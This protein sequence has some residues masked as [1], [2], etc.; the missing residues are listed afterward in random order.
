[1]EETDQKGDKGED[2]AGDSDSL[3]LRRVPVGQRGLEARS[4]LARII[5]DELDSSIGLEVR[6]RVA[7]GWDVFRVRGGN[8]VRAESCES[9]GKLKRAQNDWTYP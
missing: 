8:W 9:A 3:V 4:Y 7:E 1:M 5:P 2:R 6:D